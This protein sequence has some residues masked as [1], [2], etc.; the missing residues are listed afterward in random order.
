MGA[1]HLIFQ[2]KSLGEKV[3]PFKKFRNE[4]P[5]TKQKWRL[6]L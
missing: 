5:A 1:A 6:G 3:G 4:K 2:G